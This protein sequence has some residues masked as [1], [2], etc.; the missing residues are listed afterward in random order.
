MKLI[1][2]LLSSHVTKQVPHYFKVE[3]AVG[4]GLNA[5][6]CKFMHPTENNKNRIIFYSQY[7]YF[8]V[9]KVFISC[10]I[11][12]ISCGTFAYP[13]LHSHRLCVFFYY[14]F[15]DCFENNICHTS[16]TLMFRNGFYCHGS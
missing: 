16:S 1:S 10:Y 4:G 5:F 15:N 7:W 2:P 12:S 3:K 8:S 14:Y 13:C 9:I 11:S 6:V